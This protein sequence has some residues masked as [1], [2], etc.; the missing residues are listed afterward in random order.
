MRR[1]MPEIPKL[2]RLKQGSRECKASL[3]FIMGSSRKQTNK[4]QIMNSACDI[5]LTNTE[6]QRITNGGKIC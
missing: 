1:H 3:D 2:E 4:Q 5:A 6:I